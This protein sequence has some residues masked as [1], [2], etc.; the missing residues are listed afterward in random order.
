MPVTA[1]P[2]PTNSKSD[3]FRGWAGTRIPR[4]QLQQTTTRARS[5][6]L[7]FSRS[8][9]AEDDE[10][11]RPKSEPSIVLNG[12]GLRGAGASACRRRKR[13]E[14]SRREAR[15][16]RPRGGEWNRHGGERATPAGI[17]GFTRELDRIRIT[18]RETATPMP[19]P[20]SPKRA[21]TQRCGPNRMRRVVGKQTMRIHARDEESSSRPDSTTLTCA[22]AIARR[23]PS[24]PMSIAVTSKSPGGRLRN[25]NIIVLGARSPSSAIV[26]ER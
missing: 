25:S 22:C 12:G 14:G 11:F 16:P 19:L 6:T 23:R 5:Y 18:R 2:S 1:S 15:R 13:V 21:R 4:W 10:R 9:Q 20:S 26:L 8:R 24:T 7:R 17:S 3:Q